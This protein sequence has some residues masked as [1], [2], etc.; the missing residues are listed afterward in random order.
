[1][2]GTAAEDLY[3]VIDTCAAYVC[4]DDAL[5]GRRGPSPLPKDEAVHDLAATWPPACVR[6]SE[7][8]CGL[9][10]Q[11]RD[12]DGH[13][14]VAQPRHHVHRVRGHGRRHPLRRGYPFD[15]GVLEA[16]GRDHPQIPELGLVVV[17]VG[18]EAHVGAAHLQTRIEAT[19]QG[20]NAHDRKKAAE[21]PPDAPE[22][23]LREGRAVRRV[24]GAIRLAPCRRGR[25]R[26]YVAPGVHLLTT[27]HSPH[28]LD[29]H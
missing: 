20:H 3:P 17:A 11:R 2:V 21:R 9:A 29:E 10:A 15:V 16:Q 24:C 8:C 25:R 13:L 6:S 14:L 26:R 28:P 12:A 18:R 1:M 5:L 22:H 7:R 23:A 27:R 19:A 4:R